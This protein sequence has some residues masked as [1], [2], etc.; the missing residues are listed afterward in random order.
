MDAELQKAIAN[1]LTLLT[2]AGSA[3]G[4]AAK[5]ELPTIIKEY[6]KWGFSNAAVW[7]CIGVAILIVGTV[8]SIKIRR[9]DPDDD[10][11]RLGGIVCQ[12][13]ASIVGLAFIIP[14][15]LTMV[16]IYVA[17]RVYLLEQARDMLTR[18]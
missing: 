13:G 18:H 8:V 14:N 15:V 2:D 7:L 9:V 12:I 11:W 16:Q 17:P 5:K 10:D 4:D 3:A 1:F 6:L